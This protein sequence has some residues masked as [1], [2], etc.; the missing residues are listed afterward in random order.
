MKKNKLVTSLFATLFLV[1][2][3]NISYSNSS[4]VLLREIQRD[5]TKY[6][7]KYSNPK[8][9]LTFDSSK[10]YSPASIAATGFNILA[11]LVAKEHNE[12]SEQK[13]YHEIKKILTT[14]KNKAEHE[15]GFFYHFVSHNSGKRIWSSEAS[16]I[17]TALVLANV[18]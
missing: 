2:F 10:Q 16:S 3:Q 13:A 7:F 12:I 5:T 18:L 1:S 8:T 17:D 11:H 9:G 6:F 15:K 4:K 14:L